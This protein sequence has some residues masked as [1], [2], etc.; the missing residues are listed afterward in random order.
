MV[1]HFCGSVFTFTRRGIS[2]LRRSISFTRRGIDTPTSRYRKSIR[3]V[4]HLHLFD[5]YP[6]TFN[7][8]FAVI[9]LTIDAFIACYYHINII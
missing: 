3:G 7:G 9:T 4:S 1:F 2:F 5:V 8:G 6:A